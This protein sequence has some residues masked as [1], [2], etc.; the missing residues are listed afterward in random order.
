M[1]TLWWDGLMSPAEAA[2]RDAQGRVN[3][4]IAEFLAKPPTRR[5]TLRDHGPW[6]MRTLMCLSCGKSQVEL[7]SHERMAKCSQ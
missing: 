2:E 7:Y 3:L 6:G 5:V 4:A 1:V